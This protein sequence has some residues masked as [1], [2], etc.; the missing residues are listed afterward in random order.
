MREVIPVSNDEGG[1]LSRFTNRVRRWVSYD[2]EPENNGK[3]IFN[4]HSWKDEDAPSWSDRLFPSTPA[5][6]LLASGMGVL[7]LG[8]AFYSLRFFPGAYRNPD[9]VIF[10]VLLAGW[11][12]MYVYGRQSMLEEFADFDWSALY[13]G[14]DL[15]VRPG[16]VTGS[17]EGHTKF[18]PMK[19]LSFGGY[20]PRFLELRDV[21]PPKEVSKLKSKLH[22]VGNDG[23]GDCIDRLHKAYT[24]AV[25]TETL[26][27]VLVT[28][29]SSLEMDK[30]GV[31]TDRYTEPPNLFDEEVG[32]R[33]TQEL[34]KATQIQIPHLQ[35]TIETLENRLQDRETLESD[36]IEPYLKQ[37]RDMVEF[38]ATI[39]N[40]N[41]RRH[42]Q[43]TDEDSGVPDPDHGD[44]G[45]RVNGNEEK[46]NA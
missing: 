13:Y 38:L 2:G 31:E 18:V 34:E 5:G 11:P 10:A 1:A 43:V 30:H 29:T 7:I 8:L 37:S 16:K 46:V 41:G 17:M 19:G 4:A 26:G 33:L 20:N 23:S 12:G 36:L 32:R 15:E 28:H 45:E 3:E 27:T 44:L 42:R 40:G 9:T 24:E 14:G 6:W 22:R 35:E 21:Y 39:Q 25:D